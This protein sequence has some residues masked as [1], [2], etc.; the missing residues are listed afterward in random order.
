MFA[1][2]ADEF[3]ASDTVQNEEDMRKNCIS[4][5]EAAEL[6]MQKRKR[7]NLLPSQSGEQQLEEPG[8]DNEA[9]K[10]RSPRLLRGPAKRGD[11]RLAPKAELQAHKAGFREV[12][13]NTLS[14]EFVDEMLTQLDALLAPGACETLEPGTVNA[15]I[16]LIAS[17]KPQN[18]LEA[19][20]AVQIVAT[21]FAALKFLRRGQAVLEEAYIS[22][23]GGYATRLLRLQLELIQALDKHRRG[24][25]QT[26]Q[27]RD[28]HIHSGAQGVVGIINSGKDGSG[29]RSGGESDGSPAP[30]NS[31]PSKS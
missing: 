12:F 25:K 18:E 29:G 5:S 30:D 10:K 19:L 11:V 26:V 14:D 22:V 17:V 23:Y 28:V 31:S 9:A 1:L 13:G 20:I 24:Q 6:A 27:A 7:L 3:E 8:S 21:G 2:C 15:A 16:V 4:G